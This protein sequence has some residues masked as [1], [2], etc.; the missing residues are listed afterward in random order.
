MVRINTVYENKLA[1]VLFFSALH[2]S[3]I[4][5]DP[6]TLLPVQD[7]GRGQKN[8]LYA[9]VNEIYEGSMLFYEAYKQFAKKINL[10]LTP[11]ELAMSVINFFRIEIGIHFRL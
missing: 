11:Y 10:Q 1:K 3:T 6:Y 5:Y 4:G 2:D 7:K 9:N 8:D